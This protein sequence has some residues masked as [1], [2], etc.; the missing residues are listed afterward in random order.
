[1]KEL[2]KEQQLKAAE[3]LCIRLPGGKPALQIITYR[4]LNVKTYVEDR[5]VRLIID[6]E[7]PFIKEKASDVEV[8]CLTKHSFT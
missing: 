1:M 4:E 8:G 2:V 6:F 7:Q 5:K 3:G